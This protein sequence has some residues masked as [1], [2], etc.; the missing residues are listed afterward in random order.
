MKS[1]YRWLV[2][3]LVL[4]GVLF[5]LRT[6]GEQGR[7]GRWSF[8]KSI[9]V[10]SAGDDHATYF[11]LKVNLA[12]QG[13]PL[14]FDIVVGCNVRIT[15]YKDNDRTVEVGVAPMVFGLRMKDG[16]GVVVRPPEAC[17]GET[18]ENGKVPKAVLPLIA[19]Y[20]GA[21]APWFGIA[22]ASEDAYDSPLSQLKFFGASISKATREE[23]QEW[24]RTEAPKNFIT[25][26]LLGINPRNSWDFPRWEPGYRVMASDCLGYSWVK[27]PEPVRD[28]V[29]PFWPSDK[30]TYW[31]PNGD[32]RRALSAALRGQTN[33]Q[34]LLDGNL[35]DSYDLPS[36]GAKGL[37]RRQPGAEISFARRVTGD[38]YPA[39]TDLSLNRLGP[40]GQLPPEIEV[41]SRLSWSEAEVRPE[42]KGFAFCDRGVF[43][44][45]GT[46]ERLHNLS[47]RKLNGVDGEPISEE[48]QLVGT[49]FDFAF[50]RDERVVFYRNYQLADIFGGL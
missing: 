5:A 25:Y 17:G 47:V 20:E 18:T 14:D 6:L 9:D 44:V 26:G 43:N 22:Y 28:A 13:E 48:L 32:T 35:F 16:H 7:L 45:E 12:Y 31:Y 30:P 19:T 27:L 24:R 11:R 37:A 4:F 42:L 2:A 3:V 39:R 46:P 49:N 41:K 36:L 21:D 33:D 50:E 15:T 34:P 1:Q 29:R 40:D 23:W 38:V 8:T 10:K